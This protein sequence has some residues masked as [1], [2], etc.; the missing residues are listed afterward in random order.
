MKRFRAS[1]LVAIIALI[2]LNIVS[3]Y[4]TNMQPAYARTSD[5]VLVQKAQKQG[6]KECYNTGV[7]QPEVTTVNTNASPNTLYFDDV[8]SKANS[9]QVLLPYSLTNIV[10]NNITCNELFFGYNNRNT[11]GYKWFGAGGS[12]VGLENNSS[13]VSNGMITDP[14]AVST[15]MSSLGYER[16]RALDGGA[17]YDNC[18]LISIR[19]HAFGSLASSDPKNESGEVCF[20]FETGGGT[21]PSDGYRYI[22]IGSGLSLME[23]ASPGEIIICPYGASINCT[24][25]NVSGLTTTDNVAAAITNAITSSSFYDPDRRDDTFYVT[26][27]NIT[28]VNTEDVDVQSGTYDRGTLRDM[29]NGIFS[30]TSTDTDYTYSELYDLYVNYYLRNGYQATISCVEPGDDSALQ[31]AQAAVGTGVGQY[32]QVT[33]YYNGAM[34][35]NCFAKSNQSSTSE[36]MYVAA[37]TSNGQRHLANSVDFD[38]LIGAINQ[39]A[40]NSPG[41]NLSSILTTVGMPGAE[42][43][44]NITTEFKDEDNQQ[45]DPASGT[46]VNECYT[47]AASLGWF[48]CPVLDIAS[49]ALTGIYD[50]VIEP[51]LQI[52]ASYFERGSNNGGLYSGWRQFRDFANILFA[53]AFAI[54]ILAQVTGIGIS[55]YNV[56]KILPRLIMVAVLVN[57]SFV[58]CQIA[59]DISN[60]AGYGVQKI[61]QDMALKVTP[62]A[63]VSG[64]TWF[65]LSGILSTATTALFAV[66]GGAALAVSWEAWLIP[67]LL[68]VLCCLLSVL[69]FF[70]VLGIRQAGVLILITA[71]P[72]A[73][74]CYALPNTKVFFDKWKRI[75]VSLLVVYPICGALIGGG[76]FASALLV[77]AGGNANFFFSL[78]AMLVSVVPFFMIPSILRSSMAAMG[79]LGVRVSQFGQNLG[80]RASAGARNSEI[81]RDAQRQLDKHNAARTYDRINRLEARN[82]HLSDRAARRRSR[83]AMR[84]NRAA[85]EDIRAGGGQELLRE[86]SAAYNAAMAGQRRSRINEDIAGRET[87]FSTSAMSSIIDGQTQPINGENDE[88]LQAELDAYLDRIIRNPNNEG[89]EQIENYSRNAQA[90]ANV[91]SSR[92]TGSARARVVDSLSRAMRDNS[93]TLMGATDAEKD[94][95]VRH[96]GSIG[97]RLNSQ[98]GKDYKKDNP[99]S[100]RM[101]SDIASGDFSHADT[102]NLQ[103]PDLDFDGNI[104]RDGNGD[105]VTFVRSSFY[106]GEGITGMKVEDFSK[107]KT[108]GLRNLLDGINKGDISGAKARALSDMADKVLNSDIYTPDADAVPYMQQ[109]RTAAFNSRTVPQGSI[110]SLGSTAI[111]AA[112]SSTISSIVD[113]FQSAPGD[114]SNLSAEQQQEYGNLIS[115]IQESMQHDSFS[116]VDARK[117]QQAM[118]IARDKNFHNAAGAQVTDASIPR[119]TDERI[120]IDHSAPA[121]QPV[122]TPPIPEG[123]EASGKWVGQGRPTR[124]QRIAY[125]KWAERSAEVDMYNASLNN[126]NNGGNNP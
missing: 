54:V 20:D 12:I 43:D 29:F 82:G 17:S 14:R 44:P 120:K 11:L 27:V 88:E 117:L 114:W 92:G 75:F 113:K 58:L 50:E 59:V 49:N 45:N 79:N 111:G 118:T 8:V 72:I 112:S 37:G 33:L 91:L 107:L 90:I 55:N 7:I 99:G 2:T 57:I 39:L 21:R 121:P 47:A 85:I 30:T 61:F 69:F 10:D 35:K 71:A 34:N 106:S 41:G 104:R 63:G 66:A 115:N 64:T 73:I 103:A 102:F 84:Y 70:I 74:V 83:A 101:L 40:E 116:S 123:W 86:G 9:P 36:P 68:G 18:V 93:T 6:V 67:F 38:G 97:S 125:Q 124:Q 62:P 19:Y 78:V 3:L 81:G 13:N 51:F 80:H 23:A 96:F 60:I 89:D 31:V 26:Q 100:A 95:L 77:V 110:R 65:S 22:D 48:L 122:A 108:S 42:D 1:L 52:P 4:C 15:F 32:R 24:T 98:F 119:I 28:G 53:V 105:P 76:Q 46:G 87:L 109:I 126:H 5:A 25:T 56:K 94:R 16:D